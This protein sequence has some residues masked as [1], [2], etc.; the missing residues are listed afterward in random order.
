MASAAAAAAAKQPNWIRRHRLSSVVIG[1]IVLL[2]AVISILG[3][4][5]GTV[6]TAGLSKAGVLYLGCKIQ[7]NSAG[8]VT[9]L[10]IRIVN[11]TSSP[12]KVNSVGIELV[13]LGNALEQQGNLTF[14][15][16]VPPG[17]TNLGSQFGLGMGSTDMTCRVG[18]WS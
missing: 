1:A 10:K 11:P 14:G 4:R 3:T 8:Q 15:D 6:S 12:V 16:S 7:H 18:G 13:G 9:Q 5:A 2:V 17:G